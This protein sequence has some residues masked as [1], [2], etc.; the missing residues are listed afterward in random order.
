[1][2]YKI[3]GVVLV[4]LCAAQAGRADLTMRHTLTFKFGSFLPQQATDAI[5]Q[6]LGNRMAEG[7]TTQIKGD[8]VYTS[9]GQMFS[10]TDYAKGEITL[11]EPKT[12]RFAT[13]PLAE[14]PGK[15]LAA[16]QLPPMPPDAQRI[17][18]SMKLEVKTSKT[19]QTATIHEI[20]AEENVLVITME[21]TAGMQMRSEIHIWAASPDELRRTPELRELAAY[22][23]RP[24]GG[25]DP[26]EM[27]TKSL[28]G[29]P[30]MG[31]KLRGPMQE[32]MKAAGGAVIRMRAATYMTGL[33]QSMG[34]AAGGEPVTEVTMDLAELTLGPIPDSRFEIPAGYQK[35]PIEDLLT[36]M[37]PSAK[38]A[39]P[40]GPKAEIPSGETVRIQPVA[41][42]PGPGVYRVGGGVS[43]PQVLERQ[44][45]TY[46]EEARAAKIQ[47]SVLLYV[48]VGPD[49][50]A[51]QIRVL[52]SLD[53][54]LDQKAVEA[55]S[56]WKFKPGM[57]E[58][59]PVPVQAQ[60]EVNFQLK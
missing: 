23:G 19:G 20:R 5:K 37:F 40:G 17:F 57:K 30:G 60:I 28:A 6:Q 24:K 15:V 51:G 29:L 55:V 36:A 34:G 48:V 16:Q 35:A 54:G 44:E 11:V 27:M 4:G 41:P 1:M 31:E 2:K 47:G 26:M 13:L 22:A 21:V 32:M 9:M 12:R 10:V 8:R 18:D 56:Q 52:R 46:T 39:L 3:A 14:Y 38:P 53:V 45:P 58:G 7:T 50:T 25:L 42:A 49:G 43:A 33:S 59:Q